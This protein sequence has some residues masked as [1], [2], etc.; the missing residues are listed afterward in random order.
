MIFHQR[1]VLVAATAAQFYIAER[2]LM[3]RWAARV[4]PLL[5]SESFSMV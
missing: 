5:S 1:E 2:M 3:R 4:E